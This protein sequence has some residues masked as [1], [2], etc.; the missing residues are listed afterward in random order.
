ME[1]CELSTISR[2]ILE[3]IAAGR[4]YDQILSAG[5]ATTYHDIFHSAKEA[6]DIVEQAAVG[7]SYAKRMDKIRQ[8]RPRAYEAWLP[9]EN[10]GLICL[11]RA[12]TTIDEIAIKLQR[13]PSAIRRRLEKLKLIN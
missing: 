8:A 5:L 1:P 4:S 12:G 11:F 10:S 7:E 2:T 13:Q 6:L 3:G 9:E